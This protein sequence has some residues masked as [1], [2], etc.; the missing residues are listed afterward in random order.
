MTDKNEATEVKEAGPC[1]TCG[2][3][4]TGMGLK[5]CPFCGQA[6]RVFYNEHTQE[7]WVECHCGVRT[8]KLLGGREGIL[9]MC[10]RW[11]TRLAEPTAP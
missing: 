9:E 5:P 1:P 4:A 11:N 6:P 7:S 2:Q 3:S 8:N 10:Q